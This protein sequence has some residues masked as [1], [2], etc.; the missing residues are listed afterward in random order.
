MLDEK[1]WQ[2]YERA[3]SNP[4]TRFFYSGKI[5]QMDQMILDSSNFVSTDSSEF[6]KWTSN[7]DSVGINLEGINLRVDYLEKKYEILS[8][9]SFY[10]NEKIGEVR[11]SLERVYS[12][13]EA[14]LKEFEKFEE[15]NSDKQPLDQ[16]SLV[17]DRIHGND[18]AYDHEIATILQAE[19][20]PTGWE[21]HEYYDMSGHL[22]SPDGKSIVQYDALASGYIEYRVNDTNYWEL[23]TESFSEFKN[24]I[25][26][27]VSSQILN[28]VTSEN[29]QQENDKKFPVV[30]IEMDVNAANSTMTQSYQIER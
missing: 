24:H 27:Q 2:E 30:E 8:N 13:R 15:L 22:E 20:L 9:A 26:S 23:F 1:F 29:M 18:Q 10:S 12:E 3:N 7:R 11:E 5:E 4:V 14:N 16:P 28:Q 6:E 19:S 25:E 21:W 17:N